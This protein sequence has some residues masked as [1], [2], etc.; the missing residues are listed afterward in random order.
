MWFTWVCWCAHTK[1]KNGHKADLAWNLES[2]SKKR[3]MWSSSLSCEV[4]NTGVGMFDL[5]SI[6]PA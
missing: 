5:S 3:V 1:G 2:D 4:L 6:S